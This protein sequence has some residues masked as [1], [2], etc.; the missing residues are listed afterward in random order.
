MTTAAWAA[1]GEGGSP[2]ALRALLALVL[3]LGPARARIVLPP[4]VAWYLLA[5]PGARAASR[6]YLARVL[7]RGPRR[8]D[9]V[10]HFRNFA[11]AVLDR[12]FLLAGRLD[13][14]D[15]AV[16]GEAHV[17]AALA[18][19]RGC[20]LL[21]AHLGSFEVLRGIA[22]AAPV[23][24]RPVMYRRNAGA[25]TALLDALAPGLRDSVIEIGAADSMLRAREAVQRGEIVGLLA[26]RSPS[27][28]RVVRV[29]FLG[30]DAA[31]PAGPFIFAATLDAP[32]VLFYGVR[33]GALRY[34][35][36]FA[37]FA[38]RLVLARASRAEDLRRHVGRYAARLEEACRADPFNWFNFFPFWADGSVPHAARL[39][40][41]AAAAED[42]G[43]RA[44]TA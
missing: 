19:G 21:G 15:I 20:V 37:P 7:G 16:E 17:Q 44:R 8:R 27:G 33:T 30:R 41:V 5:A 32:V 25:L 6:E 31:F 13:A 28:E 39:G 26:D 35:V 14:F 9:V 22:R 29:P 38:D 40:A 3:R 2:L 1:R 12:V 10:A 36:R 24:V 23:P 4:L 18:T 43:R 42:R 34:R 11:A